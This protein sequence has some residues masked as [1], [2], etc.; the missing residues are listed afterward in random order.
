MAS[1][2]SKLV[3]IKVLVP[4][5]VRGLLRWHTNAALWFCFEQHDCAAS[6]MHEYVMLPHQLANAE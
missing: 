2:S 6:C 1:T 5:Q 4:T 3:G